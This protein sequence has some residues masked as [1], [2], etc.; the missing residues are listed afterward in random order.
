MRNN[1]TSTNM[2]FDA[3]IANRIATSDRITTI[4]FDPVATKATA[5][6][7]TSTTTGPDGKTT[8]IAM[9][10]AVDTSLGTLTQYKKYLAAPPGDTPQTFLFT[11]T[12]TTSPVA[13]CAIGSKTYNVYQV[14]SALNSGVSFDLKFI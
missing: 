14:M 12:S 11:K 3:F 13:T 2:T 6:Y 10:L 4:A 5:T 9:Y 8:G 1:A 7:A